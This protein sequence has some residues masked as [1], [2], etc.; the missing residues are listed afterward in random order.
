MEV[1]D[2]LKWIEWA[3]DV[4]YCSM[5]DATP[6]NEFYKQSRATYNLLQS[7][8]AKNKELK[9]YKQMWRDLYQNWK[10][11]F[12]AY[13]FPYSNSVGLILEDKMIELEQKYLKE[14]TND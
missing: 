8:E 6:C 14:A 1:K 12:I 7:L 11:N 9:L 2:A 5:P 4:Y 13:P 3:D 10:N